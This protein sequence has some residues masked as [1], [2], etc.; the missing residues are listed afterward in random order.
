[1][2]GD[3]VMH[4]DRGRDATVGFAVRAERP[5]PQQGGPARTP[6]TRPVELPRRELLPIL[7]SGTRTTPAGCHEVRAARPGAGTKGGGRHQGLPLRRRWEFPTF[8]V[9]RRLPPGRPGLR[10]G[11]AARVGLMRRLRRAAGGA[12][13]RYTT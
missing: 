7:G 1:M 6:P 9:T 12:P 11:G 4:L 2:R 13:G 5:A 10:D 3:G 8:G